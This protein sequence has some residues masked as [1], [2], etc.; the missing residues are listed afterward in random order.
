MCSGKGL[1]TG[2]PLQQPLWKVQHR[3]GAL[4][5]QLWLDLAFDQMLSAG[6]EARQ[7]AEVH[8]APGVRHL[9]YSALDCHFP[10]AMQTTNFCSRINRRQNLQRP[11]ALYIRCDSVLQLLIGIQI[12]PC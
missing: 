1:R 4:H 7:D 11:L 12:E 2:G 8:A 6:A 5:K 3:R 10:R 9:C